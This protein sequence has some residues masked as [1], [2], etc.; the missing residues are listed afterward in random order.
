MAT[1]NPL[2]NTELNERLRHITLLVMDVDGVLTDG[3]ITYTDTDKELKSFNVKDGQGISYWNQQP[4]RHSAIITA[5]HSSIVARRGT[6]LGIGHVYLGEK[7]KLARLGNLLVDLGLD[8]PQVAYMGDDW[9]DI[10][11]L[12]KV[13][14]CGGLATCP[15]DAVP[16]VAHVAHW[17]STRNGGQGAVREL[18]QHL[19]TAQGLLPT[20]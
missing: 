9:P 19:L 11:C 7:Q 1:P 15:A 12:Q 3:R 18:I 6:E 10:G 20:F 17:Q 8:W 2:N 5:R 4:N 16:E 14:A 13:G